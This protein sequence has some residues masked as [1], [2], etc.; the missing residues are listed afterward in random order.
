MTGSLTHGK[1]KMTC[2]AVCPIESDSDRQF[3]NINYLR[4]QVLVNHCD[5]VKLLTSRPMEICET[6]FNTDCL[7]ALKVK[8][9]ISLLQHM[10]LFQNMSVSTKT[11]TKYRTLHPDK[12]L[13]T[14]MGNSV[15][16]LV[17]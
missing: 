2:D 17:T 5:V 15:L 13:W 1:F 4:K 16:L 6:F 14:H 9:I 12:P 3:T 10:H 8:G 7:S 11:Y